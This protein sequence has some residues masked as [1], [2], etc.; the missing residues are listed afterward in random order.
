MSSQPTLISSE[1]NLDY[2]KSVSKKYCPTIYEE[3][4]AY[5]PKR[6]SLPPIELRNFRDLKKPSIEEQKKFYGQEFIEDY[7]E[8]KWTAELYNRD[9]FLRLYGLYNNAD[10]DEKRAVLVKL[11]MFYNQILKTDSPYYVLGLKFKEF[12][13]PKKNEKEVE[14]WDG[15]MRKFLKKCSPLAGAA[16]QNHALTAPPA[17]RWPA[18]Q[19]L[20]GVIPRSQKTFPTVSSPAWSH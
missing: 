14:G 9:T 13:F 1:I 6:V 20:C 18:N 15:G 5:Q 10:G 8:K 16:G 17:G 11:N 3:I 2:Y 4:N 7:I 19:F 12:D